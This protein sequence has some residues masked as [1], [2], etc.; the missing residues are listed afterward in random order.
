MINLLPP[1]IKEARSYGRRNKKLLSYIIAVLTI[2][3]LS[4]S[5]ILVNFSLIKSEK[6]QL[7]VEM[8][9]REAE[10]A[11][12]KNNQKDI[13]KI[14]AQLAVIDKLYAS[15]VQFS[16]VIPKI[17]ALLPDGV[18]LN[19]LSLAGGKTSPLQLDVDMETQPLAAVF[20]QNL[21]NSDLFEAADI[22]T[23]VSKGGA[24]KP[25]TKTYGYGAALMANFKGTSANKK[26]P[27][28]APQTSPEPKTGQTP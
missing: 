19:G 6:K 1:D 11:K 12:L 25:G 28:A 7:M 8:Q 5:I 9:G 27:P 14:A 22:S 4:M 16:Q 20:Q 23:I 2:G 26:N 17:G 18:V 21:M 13:D 10:I 24:P 3:S 15:E